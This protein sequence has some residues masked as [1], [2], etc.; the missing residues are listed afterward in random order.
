M[1]LVKPE[2]IIHFLKK[3]TLVK[4]DKETNNTSGELSVDQNGRRSSN[5]QN[6][7]E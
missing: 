2:R 1:H 5:C 7:R 6:K 4:K 3:K